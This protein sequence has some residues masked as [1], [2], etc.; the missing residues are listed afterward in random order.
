[1]ISE[2]DRVIL[3]SLAKKVARIAELPIMEKR[4]EMWKRHNQLEETRPL[5]LV[6]PEGSWR[7]ILPPSSLACKGEEAREM[8]RNL[9]RRIFYH[10][11]IEDDTVI[12]KNWV[13][14]KVITDSGWGIESRHRLSQQETGAWGFDPVINGPKDLE[15]LEYPQVNC[16]EEATAD[17]LEEAEEIFGDI[18]DVQLKG[19]AHI[20][21][22]LMNLYCKLRGLE[23]VMMD[24]VK[25]PQM[26]HRAMEILEEGHRR[27]VEQYVELNLLSLNNDGTYHSSGGVGYSTELPQP[28]YEPD[29]IRPCDM[30]ASAEA[31]EMA[32][33]S[34]A[35]HAEFILPYEKRLLE[36][37]GLNGYGCCEDLTDKLED[38]FTIPN[39]RRI[40][41]SPWADVEECAQKLKGDYIFSWKPDPSYLAGDTFDPKK[42]REYVKETLEFT[43]SE[44]CVTEV[45]LKDTHTCENQPQRFTK[46]TEVAK[47][48]VRNY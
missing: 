32:Q 28:D 27:R 30:W 44:G 12:E 19:I 37:F 36:P 38:V 16:D 18:L 46:W 23:Q 47:D 22:H 21:F 2:D 40:S 9:R 24:M 41:I 43:A 5:L 6:F 1:M 13:V 42:V 25:N 26:L 14:S 29:K 10:E 8:E 35:M 39:I 3:R 4:K 11:S 20:S 48:L 45:I 31:Q 17:K 33:V 15:K 34:P 7:E